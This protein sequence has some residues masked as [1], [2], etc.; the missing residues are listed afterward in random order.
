MAEVRTTLVV[1][2]DFPP[3]VGGIESFVADLCELLDHD[4]VVLTSGPPGADRT[5]VDRGYR[6][7]RHSG[8]GGGS[9]LLPT[10]SV[11]RRA[12]ALLRETGASR[13]VFGAA[14]PLGL[15]AP[16]LRAAGARHLLGLT[17]GHEIWW[18]RVPG[19]RQAL[20]R[21]GDGCDHLSTISD[22]TTARI[23]PA[24]SPQAGSRLVRL[25][26]P[27]DLDRFRP[28]AAADRAEGPVRCV[29]VGRFV[30]QKGFGTLL[31]AWAQVQDTRAAGSAR[32]ELVL[33]GD[34]PQRS[35]LVRQA[36]GLEIS[37]AVRFTGVLPRDGVLGELQRARLFALPV[38]TRFAGLNPE[39][40]GLAA[41]EA[42]ACGLPVVT[43]RSGGAPETVRDGETGFV[44]EPGDHDGLAARLGELLADPERAARMGERGRRHVAERF[45]SAQVR[46]TLRR[47]LALA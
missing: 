32:P 16:A 4:V 5:D 26:P 7:V 33:V 27:V 44:V 12:A 46:Q 13:V 3:R 14:A 9:L 17:H 37:E 19:A 28:G 29:A 6:V 18:A 8:R 38:A 42:A 31:R 45:G 36:A 43:G 1:T 47:A 23:R 24:L 40:L 35:A 22:F 21:I 11:A 39:G 41:L 30:A 15:L 25:T 34:G 20:R 2:N 10:P